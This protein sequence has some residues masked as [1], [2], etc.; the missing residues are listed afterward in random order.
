MM[1]KIG[2]RFYFNWQ[3][4]ISGVPEDCERPFV[5]GGK[6]PFEDAHAIWSEYNAERLIDVSSDQMQGWVG[7]TL[8]TH[9]QITA[10]HAG[11]I[12]YEQLAAMRAGSTTTLAEIKVDE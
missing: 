12:T 7:A 4:D 11:S 9:G 10:M 5:Y 1:P 8:I 3:V 6:C 2:Q